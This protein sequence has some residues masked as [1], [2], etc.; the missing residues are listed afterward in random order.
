MKKFRFIATIYDDNYGLSQ[1]ND[2]KLI[3]MLQYQLNEENVKGESIEIES[4]EKIIEDLAKPQEAIDYLR[5]RANNV[6]EVN[7]L[8]VL[9]YVSRLEHY[10]EDLEK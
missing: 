4:V 1:V 6:G 3:D 5:Y 7:S 2:D 10:I 8:E 9:E